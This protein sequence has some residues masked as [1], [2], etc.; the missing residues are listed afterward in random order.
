MKSSAGEKLY[1][2]RLVGNAG[3]WLLALFFEVDAEF[4]RQKSLFFG[5]LLLIFDY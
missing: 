4:N 1:F 2:M 3:A 5:V